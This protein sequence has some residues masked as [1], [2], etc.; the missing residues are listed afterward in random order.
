MYIYIRFIIT[1]MYSYLSSFFQ[2]VYDCSYLSTDI[3]S[4]LYMCN[5]A[6][7]IKHRKGKT[8]CEPPLSLLKCGEE[9]IK[10][11]YRLLKSRV[12]SRL[13][14]LD[15]LNAK[16]NRLFVLRVLKNRQTRAVSS[17]TSKKHGPIGTKVMDKH[18]KDNK[19][20][21]GEKE[22][23]QGSN[24]EINIETLICK[25]AGDER[26]LFLFELS[27]FVCLFVCLFVFSIARHP[28]RYFSDIEELCV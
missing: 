6:V 28:G 12:Q 9:E 14:T 7:H 8:W 17:V 23:H 15:G 5:G 21:G 18:R 24:C 26:I 3:V 16:K 22:K 10:R 20:G 2:P 27:F 1:S 19:K 25:S 13:C 4:S 11:K